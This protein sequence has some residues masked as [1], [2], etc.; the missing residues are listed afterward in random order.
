MGQSIA[1]VFVLAREDVYKRLRRK[2]DNSPFLRLP[3][4]EE[5]MEIL[6]L[7]FTPEEVEIALHLPCNYFEAMSAE[8]V[9]EKS[10]K[11]VKYVREVLERLVKKGSIFWLRREG[12][13]RYSLMP[14]FGFFEIPFSDGRRD[15]EARRMAEL[16][17]KYF[18]KKGN[19]AIF[20]SEYPLARVLPV[21]KE[22]IELNI[23]VSEEYRGI[24]LT[25]ENVKEYVLAAERYGRKIALVECA[26]RV[27]FQNCD[28]PTDTCL[29]FGRTAEYFLERR[30]A[31]RELTA[32]EAIK[33][34]KRNVEAGLVLT[35][36]NTQ[37]G[38]DFICS[39][40]TCC[41]G[42][43]RGLVKLNNPRAIARSNFKPVR[44]GELCTDCGLCVEICP[45]NAWDKDHNWV[46]EQCIG[47]GLCEYHCLSGAIKMVKVKDEVPE[48]SPADAWRKIAETRISL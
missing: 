12:V 24:I 36:N 48:K 5:I 41:C 35:T 31:L 19:E 25:F 32:A 28:K 3:K 40:C 16:W 29:V 30:K 42:L 21:K 46:E 45:M 1:W 14:V 10:G 7:R 15:P 22:T 23:S 6:K 38:Q 9:A 18:D 20:I 13:D 26:C 34:L 2:I 39:C 8:E 4:S 43:L 47:C 27:A 33:I 11:G 44:H 37:Y 17:D